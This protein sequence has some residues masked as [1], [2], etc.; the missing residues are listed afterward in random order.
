VPLNKAPACLEESCLDVALSAPAYPYAA[1]TA[2]AAG[3]VVPDTGGLSYEFGL[4]HGQQMV[5]EAAGLTVPH[6]KF[7]TLPSGNTSIYACAVDG[8]GARACSSRTLAVE[9]P[10]DTAVSHG[11]A[12][13][14][15]GDAGGTRNQPVAAVCRARSL[16]A[17]A[18]S[19]PPQGYAMA[20]AVEESA[21]ELASAAAE[22]G[23]AA[24]TM[25]VRG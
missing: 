7:H 5:P 8:H 20:A 11:L 19:L 12:A 1:A 16:A 22:A 9:A 21:A 24:L 6:Y 18:T 17:A 10:E 25:Q 2:T 15:S 4:L 14:M 13:I 23:S 3:F